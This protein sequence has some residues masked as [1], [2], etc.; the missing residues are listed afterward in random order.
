MGIRAG[1]RGREDIEFIFIHALL[2]TLISSR[3]IRNKASFPKARVIAFGV[4]F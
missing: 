1:A 2:R 4:D 3:I